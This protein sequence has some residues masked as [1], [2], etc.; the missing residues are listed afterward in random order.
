MSSAMG[1]FLSKNYRSHGHILKLSSKLFYN[2]AL[3]QYGDVGII[4]SMLGKCVY[5]CVCVC[6]RIYVCLYIAVCRTDCR[7]LCICIYIYLFLYVYVYV[8]ILQ[9]NSYFNI[10]VS[11]RCISTPILRLSDM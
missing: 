10:C 9:L 3:E 4:N 2:D 8:Y 11:V 6:V 7:C 5:I 1:V